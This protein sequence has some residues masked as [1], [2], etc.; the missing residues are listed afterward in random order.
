MDRDIAATLRQRFGMASFR[1]GQEEAIR[2]L[3]AGQDQLVVMPT[4]AGKSLVYQLASL[5][6]PDLTLVISPLIALMKDQV[7]AMTRQ[8]VPATF[9]NSAIPQADQ[10]ARLEAM[11]Q[12]QVRLAYVAPERLRSVRFQQ[13]LR[14]V[15]VSLL[16]VDEAHCISEWGHDFRPDYLHLGQARLQMAS[17]VTAALTATATP[18]VQ[19]DIV[20]LLGLRQAGRIITG[21][22]RPN[23]LFRV[24]YTPSATDKLTALAGLLQANG[25]GAAII[26]TGTRRDAVEVAEFVSQALGIPAEAYHGGMNPEHRTRVQDGFLSG[27]LPVVAATN[28][29]GMGID[30]P[31]VRQVIHYA[32]PGTLEAYYQEAGRAGRDGEPA[33]AALLY[34]PDDRGLQEFFINNSS[35]TLEEVRAIYRALKAMGSHKL[36]TT[37]SELSLATG[38][39][40]TKL[41]LGLSHLERAGTIETLGSDGLRMLLR[42]GTWHEKAM[43]EIHE[44][45][46]T[47]REHR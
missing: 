7:D 29:F 10:N 30:R 24:H 8:G 34:A 5:H 44:V 17:P 15:Q 21:F 43:R 32:L 2:G 40:E 36:W 26:Y 33:T 25:Q 4:G 41:K 20:H 19:Q 22:N 39:R 6:L 1:P 14:R 12:G 37:A 9:V 47:R 3:L 38:Q 35:P 31:D 46:E 11:A 28:A 23:L 13:A 18:Q 16:A 27:G 42:V 45:L